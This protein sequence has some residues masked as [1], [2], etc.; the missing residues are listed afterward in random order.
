MTAIDVTKELSGILTSAFG[1]GWGVALL[2]LVRSVLK[3]RDPLCFA[4][5]MMWLEL[6]RNSAYAICGKG[7]DSSAEPLT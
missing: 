4:I 6:L 5:L 2:F 3:K 1:M 7:G